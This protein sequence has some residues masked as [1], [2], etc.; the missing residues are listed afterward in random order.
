M[1]RPRRCRL[2]RADDVVEAVDA[3]D[4]VDTARARGDAPA[5]VYR[6]GSREAG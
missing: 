6:A 4:S 1:G 3:V 2:E 5:A